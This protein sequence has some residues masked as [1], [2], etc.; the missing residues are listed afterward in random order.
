MSV[1]GDLVVRGR[2]RIFAVRRVRRVG[3]LDIDI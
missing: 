1:R 3:E 2:M